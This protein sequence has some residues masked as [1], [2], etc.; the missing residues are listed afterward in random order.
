MN[1]QLT[2]ADKLIAVPSILWIILCTYMAVFNLEPS[3]QTEELYWINERI[4]ALQEKLIRS[5]E[6]LRMAIEDNK[7]FEQVFVR[8]MKRSKGVNDE[9]NNNSTNFSR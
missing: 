8:Y 6:R 7:A 4:T 2:T 9:R 1:N 3:S 5:D